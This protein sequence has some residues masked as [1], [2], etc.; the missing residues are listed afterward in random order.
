[1]GEGVSVVGVTVTKVEDRGRDVAGR[2]AGNRVQAV[3][4]KSMRKDGIN[5]EL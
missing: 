5:C 4:R 3:I 1:V 2:R